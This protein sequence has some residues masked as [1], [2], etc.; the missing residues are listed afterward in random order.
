M[1][2]TIQAKPTPQKVAHLAEKLGVENVIASLLVQRGI[3]TYEAAKHFF[4]PNLDDLH[5]PFSMKDME[6]AV[7]RIESA[8]TANENILVYGD[9]D[10]DGTTSV[11]LLSSYLLETYEQVTTY[12]PDRYQEGYGISYQGI[13][14]AVFEVPLNQLLLS[15]S[16]RKQSPWI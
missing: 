6:K 15:H 13:D 10:V 8:I 12:I 4:R 9:Y 16:Y 11:S 7:M 14:F 5:D 3:E 2:W 1:R